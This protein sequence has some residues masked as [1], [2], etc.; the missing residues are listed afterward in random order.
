MNLLLSLMKSFPLLFA[1]VIVT[2]VSAPLFAQDA[3]P[4]AQVTQVI[5]AN[6]PETIDGAS[7]PLTGAVSA[8]RLSA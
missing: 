5:P 2:L 6:K 1:L 4:R 8:S 7:G 3:R